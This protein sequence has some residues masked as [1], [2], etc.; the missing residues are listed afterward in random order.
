MSA[1]TENV[2][3]CF[4]SLLVGDWFKLVTSMQRSCEVFFSKATQCQVHAETKLTTISVPVVER[5]C[6]RVYTAVTGIVSLCLFLYD[7]I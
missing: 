3:I 6:G 4:G 1:I 7:V 5:S 2:C